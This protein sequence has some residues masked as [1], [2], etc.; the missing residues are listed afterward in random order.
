MQAY[1]HLV[2]RSGFALAFRAPTQ[3][4]DTKSSDLTCYCVQ[5][6]EEKSQKP[7]DSLSSQKGTS[8]GPHTVTN[9]QLQSTNSSH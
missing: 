5:T 9:R 1:L 3:F 4:Y 6:L 8:K 7:Q 2:L